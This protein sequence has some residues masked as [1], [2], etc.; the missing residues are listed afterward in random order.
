MGVRPGAP[1]IHH[2]G[3]QK[4]PAVSPLQGGSRPYKAP[5]VVAG[6]ITSSAPGRGEGRG[7]PHKAGRR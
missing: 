1:A 2:H 6:S 7:S 3:G 4:G 5:K